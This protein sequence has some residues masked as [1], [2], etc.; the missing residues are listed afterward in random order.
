[1][2]FAEVQNVFP[3]PRGWARCGSSRSWSSSLQVRLQQMLFSA[4]RLKARFFSGAAAFFLFAGLGAASDPSAAG[5]DADVEKL[6]GAHTRVVWQRDVVGERRVDGYGESFV[7]MGYDSRDGRGLRP[8][9]GETGSY[10][11]PLITPDGQQVV[12]TDSTRGMICVVNWDGSGKRDVTTGVAGELWRDPDTG[13]IWIY[14][15]EESFGEA[16][17]PGPLVRFRLDNPETKEVVW[18]RTPTHI[19]SPGSLQVSADGKKIAANMPWPVSGVAALPDGVWANNASGCWPGLAPDYSFLSWTFD[20]LHRNLLMHDPFTN[21]DW[22]VNLSEAPGVNNYEVYHPRWSNHAQFMVMTGPYSIGKGDNRLGGGGPQVDIHVGRFNRDFTAIEGWVNISRSDA[23]EFNPDVW[24]DGGDEYQSALSRPGDDSPL[25]PLLPPL[26]DRWPVS[27]EGLVFLWENNRTG[28]R[29]AGEG[30]FSREALAVAS[31]ESR[32][33]AHNEMWLH[34]GSVRV[35]GFDQAINSM[36]K[37]SDAFTVEAVLTTAT[38]KQFGPRRVIALS[39]DRSDVNFYLGQNSDRLVFRLRTTETGERGEEIELLSIDEGRPYHLVVSYGRGVFSCHVDGKLVKQSPQ[40]E[41]D[42]SN[43]NDAARLLFG[44]E[45]SGVSRQWSGLIEGIAIYDRKI[46]EEEVARKFE[47]YSRKLT[48]RPVPEITEVE[49][50]LVRRHEPPSLQDIAPYRR[51]LVLN[52]YRVLGDSPVADENG[53]VR[54]AEWILL[55]GKEPEANKGLS[56]GT[57]RIMRL[58][59][60]ENHPELESERMIGE[61]FDLDHDLYIEAFPGS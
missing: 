45:W 11:R 52:L 8:I 25:V 12:F 40:F 56:A 61:P 58:E 27:D 6:T 33:G 21:R 35:E 17:V 19:T 10:M 42:L 24:I 32:F 54:V 49:L 39:V 16:F 29:G 37:K 34:R 57:R 38:E 23:A 2:H 50:E 30:I 3:P 18:T 46:A 1:M 14:G 53:E 48:A 43:W 13:K 51:A 9:L 60:F 4:P 22:K 5:L 26:K 20:G 28:N 36:I 41:G 55:G 7:L 31:G 59:R 47:L 44:D 15:K